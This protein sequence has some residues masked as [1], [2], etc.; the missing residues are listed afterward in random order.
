MNLGEPFVGRTEELARLSDWA[1]EVATTGVGRLVLVT[2]EAG[3]G[4]TRLCDEFT[5]QLDAQGV[6]AVWSRCWEGGG[7]P[8][9]WPWPDVV[10][11]LRQRTGQS[12][13]ATSTEAGADRFAVFESVL[14]ELRTSCSTVRVVVLLDDLHVANHD[15]VLLTRF[16]AR[17]VHRMR[18]L[19]V[20]TWRLG[21]R[22]DSDAIGR[23]DSVAREATMIE[24]APFDEAGF[25]EFLARSGCD[26]LSAEERTRLRTVSGGNPMLLAE[27]VRQGARDDG[28]A[29]P[30]GLPTVL[31][32]RVASASERCRAVLGAAAVLGDGAELTEVARVTACSPLDATAVVD[33]LS[34]A[35]EVVE[36]RVRFSH[37]LW[38]EACETALPAETRLAVHVAAMNSVAGVEPSEAVW[39]A[40]HAA[41]AASLSTEHIP[42]AVAACAEAALVLQ[43]ELALEQS[44]EWAA[45]GSQLASMG[46]SSDAAVELLLIKAGAVLASGRLEDARGLFRRAAQGADRCRNPRLLA[47]AT[48]GAGG[49]WIEEVRDELSRRWLLGQCQRALASLPVGERLLAARLAVRLA[50]EHA[51]VG[52]SVEDVFARVN[53]VRGLGDAAATAEALSLLHHTLLGPQHADSRLRVADELLEVATAAGGTIYPLFGLCWKT[54]DLYLAGSADADRAFIELR[55]RSDALGCRSIGYIAAVLEVMRTIRR[56]DLEAAEHLAEGASALG[57]AVGDAD[58][59][60]YYGGHLLAIRWL[61]G[62]LAE[63]RSLVTSVI[64]SST[65]RRHDVS[66]AAVLALVCAVDGDVPAART[67][68][69]AVMANGVDEIGVPSNRMTTWAILIETCAILDDAGLAAQLADTLQPFAHLPVMPSLAIACV[70]PAE[71]FMGVACKTAG[72]PD[73]A[74]GWFRAALDTNRRLGNQPVE[75]LIRAELADLLRDGTNADRAEAAGLYATAINLGNQCEMFAR[76]ASWTASATSLD[77]PA[78]VRIRTGLIEERRDGWHIDVDGRATT[79]EPLVGLRYITLLLARPDTDIPAGELAAAVAGIAAV[80]SGLAVPVIDEQARRSYEQRIRDL[81][82]ELDT[83]DATGDVERGRRAAEERQFL[84]DHL[85]KATGLGGRTRRV[86]DDAERCRMRVSKAIHRAIRRVSEADPALG[87]ILDS[88]IRSGYVCRSVADPGNPII[89]TIRTRNVAAQA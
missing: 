12:G 27:L 19:L 40:H 48:L 4:K 67:A 80:D 42:A 79:V 60:G 84:V 34:V 38:R 6:V 39:R 72:R 65:L 69:E 82:R 58:A 16:I 17:S 24:L 75:A 47:V 50:A 46:S 33:E 22:S 61:Q 15:V 23:L 87:R 63:M 43:Q 49:V 86:S 54:V 62:R 20:A 10:R 8:P 31:Q 88:T 32:R 85:R 7:G 41:Q 70:G 11:E 36:G 26:D 66:Y 76:V 37:E 78:A 81:D 52:G 5:R 9:M 56:G 13:G 64:E 29:E 1:D 55:D 57:I 53:E 45:K 59:L 28:A 30:R 25:A 73:D 89:W 83:A 71:R 77:A 44:V 3:T 14:D 51:Y 18:L 68:L 2:G 35:A 74:V 21:P